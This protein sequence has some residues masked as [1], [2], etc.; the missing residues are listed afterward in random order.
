MFSRLRLWSLAGSVRG[1]WANTGAIARPTTAVIIPTLSQERGKDGAPG[2]L[3][4]DGEGPTRPKEGRM[5][6]PAPIL[7]PAQA[8]G[9]LERGTRRR[10]CDGA[11]YPPLPPLA[12]CIFNRLR[13][14]C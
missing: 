4:G 13:R 3:V 7:A 9:R 5:G 11:R 12:T 6:H 2:F 1:G 10:L 14:N 8:K